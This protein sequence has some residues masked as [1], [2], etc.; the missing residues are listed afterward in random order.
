MVKNVND[1]KDIFSTGNQA[2]ESAFGDLLDS[3]Y[4]KSDDSIL[5]G[6]LGITGTYGL[7]G[8][9]GGTHFG[10]LGPI[11]GTHYGLI[12]PAGGTFKGLYLSSKGATEVSPGTSGSIGETII[13]P[14]GANI[15]YMFIHDGIQWMRFTG[16]DDW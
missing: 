2:N 4:N 10:L 14:D 5:L 9:S 6:P 15:V 1:L 16:T 11:G 12:G 13:Y 7:I 3:A 8:P